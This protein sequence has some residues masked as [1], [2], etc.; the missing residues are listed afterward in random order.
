MNKYLK[1]LKIILSCLIMILPTILGGIN[2]Q[3]IDIG[4]GIDTGGA[5]VGYT[6]KEVENITTTDGINRV[7]D[8]LE[9][10]ITL[11]NDEPFST[12]KN[13][14]V[15]DTL[16]SGIDF[17][18]ESGVKK[19]GQS[20][21]YTYGQSNRE[22]AVPIGNLAGDDETLEGI[23]TPKEIIRLQFRARINET[24]SGTT[25]TNFVSA[26]GDTVSAQAQDTGI[27]VEKMVK[28]GAPVT[29][30]YQ[31]EEG[32]SLSENT[33]LSG[34][35][36]EPYT[37]V[38][39]K[40]DGYTYKTVIGNQTGLF[41]TEEQTVTFVYSKDPI[42]TSSLIVKFVDENGN[43]IDEDMILSGEVNSG[44]VF[45][46]R[47]FVGYT[48]KEVI[49]NQAGVYTVEDQT[50][51]FVYTKDP[52]PTSSVTVRYQDETGKALADD[53]VLSGE[54]GSNYSTEKK[55]F[56]GYTFKE[57]IG[58]E[59]GV[60]T[61][62]DQ[63]VTFVY[64]K[65]PI[66]TSSVTVKYQDE[67]GKAL[68]DD[69]VL[70][71]EVGANYSTEKKAFDGYTFKEVI[72]NESG[73]YTTEDQTVTFVYTK[74]PIPTSS[75]TVKYQDEEGKSLADDIVLSGEVGANYTTQK[76][77][78]DG[79]T[80]KEVIGNE[81]GVYTTEDQTVTF[82]YTKD[83]ILTS[84]VIVRF[85]DEEG[86]AIDENMVLSGPVG[87]G[88]VFIER[89]FVGYTLKKVIGNQAG[90]YTTEDQTLTFVYTKDPIPTSSV[91]V[92]FQ[93]EEGNSLAD[94]IVLS[95][96]VGANYTTQE[97][98]FDG[99]TFK[100][101]RGNEN[102]VYTT[103]DQTVTFV[104]SKDP[105]P[106][107]S[108]TVKYQDETG[109][110]L[111]DNIVL[112]G[113]VGANYTTEKKT[114]DGYTFKEVI[115]NETGV[116]TTEDQT[117][118]FVY[119]KDPI[120]TS[121]VIVRFQDEEGTA[122]DENMVLSG[123]VGTGY[124]FIERHF[125]GYTLKKV[126]GNQ[127]G[128]Y[129][130]EDQ[131]LTF[132]YTKDPI[133]T[134]SVIVKYQDETGQA[135]ADD[136]VLSGEVGS[137]YSTEKKTF[138]GYTFK[139]VIGNETGAYT[140]E[141]QTVTFVY[142]KDPIPTS[143]VTVRYQDEEGKSLAD[144]IVLSGEVGSNYSTEKKA[145]DGYTFKE[146][147]GNETGVYTTEGQTVTFVYTKDPI[148]TSS[149]TVKYQ[150]ETGKALA[151]DIILSGEVGANYTTEKKT[152]DG[153]TFKEVIGNENGVYTTE[154][155]TV[156]FVYTK[157]PIPTSSVTV[158]YQDETGKALA[159]DI[160]L[161]GEVGANYTTEKKAFDGYTFKEVIG[162]ESGVYT[163]EDQT[164]T[165][166]YTKDPIPTSSVT[167]KYQDETGKALADDIVLSGEVGANYTTQKKAFDGY[168]FKE[169]IGNESGVYTTEDQT[170]TLVYTKDPIPTSS[171]TVKYQDE[172]GKALADDIIL[173]GN[174]GAAFKTEAKLFEGYELK[175]RIGK[176][177]GFFTEATQTTTYVYIK[178][179]EGI[180]K[181]TPDNNGKKKI[182]P[183]I[184]SI[185]KQ[186]KP[187]RLPN[188]GSSNEIFSSL[189]G[190]ILCSLV[191]SF[192]VL[193]R[194]RKISRD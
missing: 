103:E 157:D 190:L 90:I 174:I 39:K 102:G 23:V 64:T 40:I 130:T 148:P 35:V 50:L 18:N 154:D 5:P 7:G 16:P 165:F 104:Y 73:V 96:E 167:V 38:E 88:Y 186:S 117:V 98:A 26:E 53:I 178:T 44:Y 51:T 124:V 25:I 109:K 194:L 151:D 62:E 134:S 1:K 123:P 192:F 91:T 184:S 158:K 146:V 67:T 27:V 65:D 161:S 129:T 132:V 137:N 69:I 181:T 145:F 97:K 28:V 120:P 133:P 19:N 43:M 112:S 183:S 12:W 71:G 36:D 107:S 11:S 55:A 9:Y 77:A 92:R 188:T 101:V 149:V 150:D 13:I 159:D 128:I 46:E 177:Q 30:I 168:T 187:K 41:S 121:S 189:L 144:D 147:R 84:S 20:I 58:N 47:Y 142:S 111:A 76:K 10:T 33:Q 45:I 93:D 34:N 89:H 131:T 49:G 126:I 6:K 116:Y 31:D 94:D 24:A 78:F 42:P 141:D 138:D 175:E 72:G 61:T 48:L 171:V 17:N 156:T 166:V 87:T 172:T 163:T 4:A 95:G 99:Y 52:V 160:V 8:V 122:I 191:L 86:T 118:T 114:F 106:T 82:V 2:V 83:P 127:A 153:Y 173:S 180:N 162:N 75:V 110:A 79:Y 37:A 60:Y 3:A 185:K 193:K 135:L 59:S 66:P 100:E 108:V 57:V 182:K 32:N 140:T 85:Q 179:K 74:D 113:E 176:S 81:N 136:I 80:F 14:T 155:Q 70:S 15:F 29:V 105:I 170:V 115:G 139:E 54:V 63:T 56:D 22:L 125:V 164:I 21:A 169:V 68:A 152:F 119:T 143:S